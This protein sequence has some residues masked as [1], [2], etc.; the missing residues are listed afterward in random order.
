[1][2]LSVPRLNVEGALDLLD[3]TEEG[4][5]GYCSGPGELTAD[6]ET[7]G[8]LR[9]SPLSVV[10]DMLD[11]GLRLMLVEVGVSGIDLIL[12]SDESACIGVNSV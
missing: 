10:S 9:A 8:V 2:G 12:P 7:V 5:R 6:A 4:G 1:L 11:S 3:A